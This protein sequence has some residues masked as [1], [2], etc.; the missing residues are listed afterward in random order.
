[1]PYAEF[2]EWQEFYGLEPFGTEVQDAAQA[3]VACVLANVN[4]D[5]KSR[6][7]PYSLRDFMLFAD[8]AQAEDEDQPILL[9][10][11]EAQSSLI[12]QMLFGDA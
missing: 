7:D 4:R 11:A 9:E 10:D 1:M 6:P 5:P 8:R 12:K 2:A 3:N